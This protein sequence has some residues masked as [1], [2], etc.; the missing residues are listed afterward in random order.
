MP[1]CI[2]AAKVYDDLHTL[3]DAGYDTWVKRARKLYNQFEAI[4]NASLESF[5]CL[6][7]CG[8]KSKIKAGFYNFIRPI[9]D[10]IS[11]L[12]QINYS[13]GKRHRNTTVR[14]TTWRVLNT[15]PRASYY[16]KPT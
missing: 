12:Q 11:W 16:K 1:D 3:A 5:L 7:K 9:V 8:M 15:V 14:P 2:P 13:A 4:T 6:S 10:E